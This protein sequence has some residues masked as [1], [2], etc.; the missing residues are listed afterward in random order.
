MIH[1]IHPSHM[2]AAIVQRLACN[3]KR[4]WINVQRLRVKR[5]WF[6]RLTFDMRSWKRASLIILRYT[7]TYLNNG[8][9]SIGFVIAVTDVVFTSH[10]SV[11]K[12]AHSNCYFKHDTQWKGEYYFEHEHL[13]I[14]FVLCLYRYRRRDILESILL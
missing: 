6:V 10:E 14:A 7:V 2:C 12:I 4:L 9:T 3:V 13:L 8:G 11:R 1:L 5:L